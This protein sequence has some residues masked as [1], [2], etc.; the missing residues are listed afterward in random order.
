MLAHRQKALISHHL[1]IAQA[2]SVSWLRHHP[3]EDEP[4]K[5]SAVRTISNKKI[6]S[7]CQ[8]NRFRLSRPILLEE[9]KEYLKGN[10]NRYK[11]FNP[12][13][14][15]SYKIAK[16]PAEGTIARRKYS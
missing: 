8:T 2:K 5:T 3:S 7:I 9:A 6:K 16:S 4:K 1:Q 15:R 13:Q 11:I 10:C 12:F 14:H